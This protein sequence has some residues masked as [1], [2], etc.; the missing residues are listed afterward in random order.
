MVTAT[1]TIGETITP[2]AQATDPLAIDS[3]GPEIMGIGPEDGGTLTNPRPRIYGAYSDSGSK[4]DPKTLKVLLNGK[5]ITDKVDVTEAFFSYIPEEDMTAGK[6]TMTVSIQDIAGNESRR[7][8][9]FTVAPPE[10]TVRNMSITPTDRAL[11]SDETLTVRLD[12]IAGGI[13]TFKLGPLSDLPMQE[14]SPG[15]YI[16]KYTVKKGDSVT[17]APVTITFTPPGKEKVTLNPPGTITLAAGPPAPPI[18]D[19]PYEGV[20]TR[21]NYVILKGRATPDVKVRIKVTYGGRPLL[22]NTVN[23]EVG[24]V[25]VETDTQGNWKSSPILLEVKGGFKDIEFTAEV[26][27]VRE[28]NEFSAPST[29]RFKR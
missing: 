27:A 22:G 15:V 20:V 29:V 16:G 25:E 12:G 19:Y 1:M 18:I 21:G 8:W 13:A 11:R 5:D 6:V 28:G 7:E 4:A 14:E 9:S 24:V 23:G 26:I 17:K 10:K 3:A 2:V